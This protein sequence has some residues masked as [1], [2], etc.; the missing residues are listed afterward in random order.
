MVHGTSHVVLKRVTSR[1]T[2]TNQASYSGSMM[3]RLAKII[4][5][6]SAKTIEPTLERPAKCQR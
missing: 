5:R 1:I 2:F 6:W 3:G 4:N